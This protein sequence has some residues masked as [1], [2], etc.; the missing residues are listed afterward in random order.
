MAWKDHARPRPSQAYT[1]SYAI[2]KLEQPEVKPDNS[3]APTVS[4][5]GRSGDGATETI[6]VTAV[7][8]AS[9]MAVICVAFFCASKLCMR[10]NDGQDLPARATRCRPACIRRPSFLP[11]CGA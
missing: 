3:E 7:I 8:T 2:S 1:P 10:G 6:I 9:S 11:P 4:D 5:D